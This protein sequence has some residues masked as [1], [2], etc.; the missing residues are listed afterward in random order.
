MQPP[1]FR[2]FI[3]IGVLMPTMSRTTAPVPGRYPCLFHA[4]AGVIANS[5]VRARTSDFMG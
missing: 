2:T 3:K 1:V 5:N 4:A